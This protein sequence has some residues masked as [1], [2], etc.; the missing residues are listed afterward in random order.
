MPAYHYCDVQMKG[1]STNWKCLFKQYKIL[2]N[3]KLSEFI[4]LFM[5]KL[6]EF[7]A[8]KCQH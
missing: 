2:V 5:L 6:Q 4:A 8:Y 7:N 3:L 1:L